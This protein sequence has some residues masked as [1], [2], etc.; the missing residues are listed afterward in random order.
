[1][2]FFE[3]KR[4]WKKEKTAN[5]LKK[6]EHTHKRGKKVNQSKRPNNKK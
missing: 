3:W 4:I 5:R 1:V 6:E 2:S